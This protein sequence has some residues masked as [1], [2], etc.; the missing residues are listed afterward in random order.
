MKYQIEQSY[1]SRSENE[2][3]VFNAQNQRIGYYVVKYN[4]ESLAEEILQIEVYHNP[5]SD[6]ED[7]LDIDYVD[8][9]DNAV[10]LI[11]E[12]IA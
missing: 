12:S 10:A 4:I 3:Q 9:E 11:L 7:F 6:F 1:S 8:S 5:D 2:Y